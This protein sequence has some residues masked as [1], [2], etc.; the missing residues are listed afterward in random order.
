MEL[1]KFGGRHTVGVQCVFGL[2]L[3]G[4]VKAL[5][6]YVHCGSSLVVVAAHCSV[7]EEVVVG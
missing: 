2:V 6:Q 3:L 5:H 4:V 7:V 1:G